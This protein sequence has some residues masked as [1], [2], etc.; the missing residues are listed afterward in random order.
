VATTTSQSESGQQVPPALVRGQHIF[1]RFTLQQVLGRGGMGVVWLAYDSKLAR[2]VALK[3]LSTEVLEDAE[4]L[5]ELKYETRRSLDS[6]H[7][8]IIRVYDFFEDD[9]NAAISMEYVNGV[10]LATLRMEQPNGIFDT[11]Q[12]EPWLIQI[13]A[14]LD[15]AHIKVELV[16]RDIK[17]GNIIID[18]R[19]NV[20]IADFGV[21]KRCFGLSS[22]TSK[23]PPPPIPPPHSE[24]SPPITARATTGTI[25]SGTPAYM[26]PQ[27]MLCAEPAPTDDIYSLGATLYELLTGT[28]PFQGGD[29]AT[30]IQTETP[31]PIWDR[32]R[33]LGIG[34]QWIPWRW[35]ETVLACLDKNPARRPQSAGEV[36]KGLGLDLQSRTRGQLQGPDRGDPVFTASGM[37]ILV[38][39]FLVVGLGWYS[40]RNAVQVNEQSQALQQLNQEKG[41]LEQQLLVASQ[42]VERLQGTLSK[43][44]R[45][46][47]T[48]SRAYNS[49]TV[50]TN[51]RGATAVIGNEPPQKTPAFFKKLKDGPYTL[52]IFL[53]GHEPIQQILVVENGEKRDLGVIPLARLNGRLRV[54][55]SPSG[56]AFQLILPARSSGS[57]PQE[58]LTGTTPDVLEVPTGEYEVV[59]QQGDRTDRTPVKVVSSGTVTINRDLRDLPEEKKTE[60]EAAPPAERKPAPAATKPETASAPPRAVDK[61]PK[62]PR[63]TE[64]TVILLTGQYWMDRYTV[65][66]DDSIIF[67]ETGLWF[68]RNKIAA[69]FDNDL[70]DLA[71]V[72]GEIGRTNRQEAVRLLKI[73]KQNPRLR[74]TTRLIEEGLPSEGAGQ[75]SW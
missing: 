11:D 31:V 55:S 16:H 34:S 45:S 63:I 10:S 40:W 23:A 14:A 61:K 69:R 21:A 44:S 59:I 64:G 26:S 8:N 47:E 12:I 30:R 5:R 73:L 38:L 43:R 33:E 53:A 51:P 35:N 3:F 22:T 15:Y 25:I 58:I 7:P 52:G 20:K 39:L 57:D 56:L 32:L 1:G 60:T 74:S 54:L 37:C 41:R 42:E 28:P 6:T 72:V 49:V 66:P 65:Y 29:L 18:D 67:N 50:D 24:P 9:Q 4:S 27:Q 2:K 46:G 71:T 75:N 19:G 48:P 17:P 70:R 36:L 13:C 68:S 62:E